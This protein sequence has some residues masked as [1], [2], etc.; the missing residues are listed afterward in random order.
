MEYYCECQDP[1]CSEFRM[2]FMAY[3]RNAEC[4]RCGKPVKVKHSV[5]VEG[6][7]PEPQRF[8]IYEAMREAEARQREGKDAT[9]V[10]A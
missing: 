9:G 2:G 5:V 1:R 6:A 3:S 7:C 4:P 10:K 8:V